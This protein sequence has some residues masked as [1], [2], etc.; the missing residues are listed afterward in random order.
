NL[1]GRVFAWW[2]GVPAVLAE[3]GD[4]PGPVSDAMALPS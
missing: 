1:H 3:T 4:L 2:P